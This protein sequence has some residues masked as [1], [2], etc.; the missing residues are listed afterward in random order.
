M[1][2]R[3]E[4]ITDETNVPIEAAH[5]GDSKTMEHLHK[6]PIMDRALSLAPAHSDFFNTSVAPRLA[7]LRGSAVVSPV[8]HTL[9]NLGNGTL[10]QV[11]KVIPGLQTVEVWDITCP[12]AHAVEDASRRVQSRHKQLH[13]FIHNHLT[14]PVSNTVRLTAEGTA[15]LVIP[16]VA[17]VVDPAVKPLN[18]VYER[19]IR[20]YF[21]EGGDE[22]VTRTGFYNEGTRSL[23]LIGTIALRAAPKVA[24]APWNTVL[25][26]ANTYST[27]KDANKSSG[28][29]ARRALGAWGTVGAL[30]FEG[31]KAVEHTACLL[32]D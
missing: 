24:M 31:I 22:V 7:A 16:A 32:H 28:F 17:A 6:Y 11:D 14:T 12:V 27:Q 3:I 20:V 9:D 25:H 5:I 21:P 26:T 1:S 8:A 4:E 30:Y 19:A 2:N 29:A 15:A 10:E 23:T 13:D 18:N